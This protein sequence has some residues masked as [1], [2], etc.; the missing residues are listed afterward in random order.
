MLYELFH[1]GSFLSGVVNE[2]LEAQ[3]TEQPQALL[4][5]NQKIDRA[6]EMAPFPGNRPLG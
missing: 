6:I 4:T 5:N 2:K 3:V 1:L